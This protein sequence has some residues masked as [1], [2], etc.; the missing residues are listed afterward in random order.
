MLKRSEFHFTK[1]Y[2]RF[3]LLVGGH[4]PA[5]LFDDEKPLLVDPGVSA[6]GPLYYQRLREIA[7]ERAGRLTMLL[8]HSHFDHCGAVPYLTRR[9]PHARVAASV[10]A[11]EVLGKPSAI[12]LIRRLNAEYE[13]EMADQ[14]RGEDVSF[15]GLTIDEPLKEGDR[16]D[17]GQ[18]ESIQV[19]ETPGHTRDCL[20][21]F[22]PDSGVLIVGEAAG[23]PVG[24]LIRSGF[25]ASYGDYRET[26]EKH[27]TMKAGALYVAHV[28][29]LTGRRTV[30]DYL[31]QSLEATEEFRMKV[32]RY[33]EKFDYDH[34]KVVDALSN[35]AL[36]AVRD[37][38]TRNTPFLINLKAKV[39]AVEK[40]LKNKKIPTRDRLD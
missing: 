9:F 11:A 27:R 30:R 23:I 3:S 5:F 37:H 33:L 24:N 35:D 38:M 8:T 10:K 20:S 18:R 19:L 15:S 28:G 17:L 39:Q 2:G 13:H 25:L 1:R 4:A 14:L 21:Y 22:F 16:I 34:G 31:E 26:N 7:G 40:T 36:Y 6:F 32:A 12:D 29:I